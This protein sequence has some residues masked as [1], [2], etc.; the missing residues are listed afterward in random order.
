MNIS[1]MVG[2]RRVAAGPAAAVHG[3]G[4]AVRRGRLLHRLAGT[5][6]VL[7]GVPVLTVSLMAG[8][9]EASGGGNVTI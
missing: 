9:A 3:P 6:A 8:V 4:L 7:A 2:W 5:V 1:R